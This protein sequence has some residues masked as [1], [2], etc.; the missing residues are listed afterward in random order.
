MTGSNF[1]NWVFFSSGSAN[2][3]TIDFAE[4]NAAAAFFSGG[5]PGSSDRMSGN[6][7]FQVGA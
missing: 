7:G 2:S 3:T 1:S 5:P 6:A 4:V